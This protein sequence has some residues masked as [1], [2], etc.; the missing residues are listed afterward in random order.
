MR[1]SRRDRELRVTDGRASDLCWF[2]PL[3]GVFLLMPPL[4]GLFNE[5]RYFFGLP[6]LLVYLFAVWLFGILLT[7]LAARRLRWE[8]RGED[9]SD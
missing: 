6:L 5:S 3:V 1:R 4:L 7:A 8:S 9:P 2:L